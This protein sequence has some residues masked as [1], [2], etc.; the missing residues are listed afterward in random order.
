[1]FQRPTEISF[2]SGHTR[3]L[4]QATQALRAPWARYR[5]N[6]GG[7][8]CPRTSASTSL[9]V[10]C[11]PKALHQDTYPT[12]NGQSER[13]NQEIGRFLRSYCSSCP[14]DWADVL[15]W[16]EIAQNSLRHSSTALTPF[17]CVLGYQ[18]ALAPWH[19]SSEQVPAVDEWFRRAEA[20]WNAA[21]TRLQRAV[22]RFKSHAD[23]RRGDAPIFQPGDRVWISTRDM[24]LHTPCRKLS[25]RYVGPFPILRQV[26]DVSFAVQLPA[27]L[28][29]SPVFH[30]SL[31]RPAVRGPLDATGGGADPPAP[32]D[33]DGEAAYAVR[34]LLDSRRRAGRLQ[35]LVDWEGFG[36]EERS[37]VPA[38]DVLDPSLCH[39]FHRRRPDRPGPRQRGRPRTLPS[40]AA[41][42]AP[43]RG[44]DVT[45]TP[46]TP[47]VYRSS[48]PKY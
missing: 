34:D 37:W 48:S 8:R 12:S 22:R 27:H 30:V 19:R 17:Q 33:V 25:P 39:D 13:T 7:P 45:T 2:W 26:N 18:P 44:G 46:A 24:K 29:L 4:P 23:R 1:M 38:C 9:P 40:S 43:W 5:Q 42:A 41:G 47:S 36:P 15:P 35:Y 3:L 21:H 31:L 10:R 20:L 32:L 28:K 11:A 16:A 14:G 6:I